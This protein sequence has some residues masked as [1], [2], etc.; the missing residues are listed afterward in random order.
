MSRKLP[1]IAFFVYNRPE[2]TQVT[3]NRLM[4]NI[5]SKKYN[6]YIFSDGPKKLKDEI[7]VNKVR[8]FIK[9]IKYFNKIK[10]IKQKKNLGLSKSVKNA[11]N[12]L[13][14]FN[15]KVIILEDDNFTNKYFLNYMNDA[16]NYFENKDYV[17]SVSGYSFTDQ[18]P[19]DYKKNTYLGYR[20]SS[21]GWGTWKH[22]WNTINWDKKWIKRQSKKKNFNNAFNIGGNDMFH[23]LQEQIKGNIDSWSI[24][25]DLNCFINNKFCVCPKKSLVQNIGFDGSGIH[26]KEDTS[27]FDNYNNKFKVSK[28]EDLKVNDKIIKNIKD[29]FK[30]SI[31]YKIKTI[32]NL[33]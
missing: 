4:K 12:Y 21:W 33:H 6:I 17:G 22:V 7:N 20:H 10:I 16:L 8:N 23:I 26:C 9:K 13:F 25:F 28:F 19:S 3:L 24:I 31:F 30:V 1:V 29:S 32:L 27:V 2:H 18:M 11:L 14:S 5:S 15:D